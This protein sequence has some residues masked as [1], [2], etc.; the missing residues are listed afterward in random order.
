MCLMWV[1]WGW[2]RHCCINGVT[3]NGFVCECQGFDCP[4]VSNATGNVQESCQ[5]APGQG[6]PA[7]I[8][9]LMVLAFFLRPQRKPSHR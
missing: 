5:T 2:R 7:L 9:L 4:P 3:P 8:M 6:S 1:C